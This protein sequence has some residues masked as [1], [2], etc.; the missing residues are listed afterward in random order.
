VKEIAYDLGYEDPAYFNRL[1]TNKT[2]VHLQ[3]LRKITIREKSTIFSLLC[4][5][6]ERNLQYLCH[7]KITILKQ[8][9]KHYET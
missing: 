4:I 5:Y 1:F 3:I 2:E 7:I 8:K 6:L 9:N